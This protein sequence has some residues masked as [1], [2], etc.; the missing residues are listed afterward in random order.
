MSWVF[1]LG[2]LIVLFAVM[3]SAAPG[4]E[5]KSWQKFKELI[6]PASGD[7]YE[8]TPGSPK[9][10]MVKSDRV[11]ATIKPGVEGVNPGKEPLTVY[12]VI[13][14]GSRQYYLEQID[15]LLHGNFETDT[16]QSVWVQLRLE[17]IERS[18]TRRSIAAAELDRS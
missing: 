12:H 14:G 16:K 3:Q 13:D 10:V 15:T 11:I 2:L 18:R 7:L 17:R 1:I 4:V 8:P 5:I 9:A 6:T